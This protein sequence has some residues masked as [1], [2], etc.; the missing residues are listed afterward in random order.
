[1]RARGGTSNARPYR[2]VRAGN[3]GRPMTAPTAGRGVEDAAPYGETR[4]RICHC[5]ASAHTGRGN[6]HPPS[7]TDGC[8]AGRTSNARPYDG[9]GR[10]TTQTRSP[11]SPFPTFSNGNL[12]TPKFS[13]LNSQFSIRPERA[14]AG[15]RGRRPLRTGA[16]QGGRAMLVPT[17][18]ADGKRLKQDRPRP[19]FQCFQMAI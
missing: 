14:G 12:K 16:G 4:S 13:I 15:R 1:M 8:G 17:T 3:G 19:L 7:P 2:R 10:E 18:G 5:E 9:R 11:P 6:P